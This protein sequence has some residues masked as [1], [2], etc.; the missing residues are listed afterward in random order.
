[1][2]T[3]E[4]EALELWSLMHLRFAL[5][6]LIITILLMTDDADAF[7]IVTTTLNWNKDDLRRG[8]AAPY[9]DCYT[10][11]FVVCVALDMWAAFSF[12]DTVMALILLKRFG[13]TLVKMQK[14]GHLSD[15]FQLLEYQMVRVGEQIWY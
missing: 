2:F 10:S 12:I 6:S 4:E 13:V 8:Y 1:M 15:S 5:Q 11:V 7:C 14:V 3:A 9:N